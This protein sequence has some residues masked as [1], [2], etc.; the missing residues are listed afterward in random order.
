MLLARAFGVA[1]IDRRGT[2]IA[3]R[4]QVGRFLLPRDLQ[5]LL[6]FPFGTG[7]RRTAVN[8]AVFA[9]RGLLRQRRAEPRPQDQN[10]D[11]EGA[12][13]LDR[14]LEMC[15]REHRLVLPSIGFDG[16]EAAV[17]LRQLVNDECG[18]QPFIRHVGRRRDENSQTL[19]HCVSLKIVTEPSHIA[20]QRAMVA[21]IT[22]LQSLPFCKSIETGF[23]RHGLGWRGKSGAETDID[24][25]AIRL[26]TNTAT[27][28]VCAMSALGLFAHRGVPTA[29]PAMSA[30]HRKRK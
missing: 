6:V 17:I 19:R 2:D 3:E 10:D 15:G 11:V 26:L 18:A 1:R 7:Y 20:E 29:S 13:R 30:V 24:R 22:S 9:L 4:Q 23:N 16:E 25:V 8:A 14:I 12:R 28:S 27:A 5:R 21:R